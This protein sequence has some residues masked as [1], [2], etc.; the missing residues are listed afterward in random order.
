MTWKWLAR[1]F[2]VEVGGEGGG[3]GFANNQFDVGIVQDI[4]LGRILYISE[5]GSMSF[6]DRVSFFCQ[7]VNVDRN[8]QNRFNVTRSRAVNSRYTKVL[9][10]SG[11]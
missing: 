9:I 7:L 5:A 10:M 8:S 11:E 6:L 1:L 2:A 4:D 3:G